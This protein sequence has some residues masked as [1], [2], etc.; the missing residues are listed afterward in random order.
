MPARDL[1][2]FIAWLKA[3]PDKASQGTAG[4]G[5]V[6][7]VTGAFF[8]KE[9]GTRFQ[10]VPYRGGN[11]LMQDLMAGHI[12]FLIDLAVNALPHVRAG[13]IKAYAVTAKSRLASAPDIP[14]VDEAGL[15]GFYTSTWFALWAPARTPKDIIGKL[16]AAAVET[17]MDPAVRR[18][19]AELGQELP[20]LEQQTPEALGALHKADIAKWWPII[21][22]ANIKA[23]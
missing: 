14:T 3:N 5:A 9:T 8:Q 4:P 10:F 21:K 22:E 18:R 23:E 15:P 13:G 2:E 17:L 1:R 20:L 16:N 19:L 11:L 7:H 6:S 12:D